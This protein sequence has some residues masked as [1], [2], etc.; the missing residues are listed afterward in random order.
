MSKFQN[1]GRFPGQPLLLAPFSL[2]MG[3]NSK[4]HS[5][6][7]VCLIVPIWQKPTFWGL[8]L[9]PRA[10]GSESPVQKLLA[11]FLAGPENLVA[12]RPTCQ[13]LSFTKWRGRNFVGFVEF[14]SFSLTNM[15][16]KNSLVVLRWF[17]FVCVSFCLCVYPS[18]RKSSVTFEPLDRLARNFQ[19]PL[20][21]LQV[22]F[23]LVTRTPQPA[24]SAKSIS[25]K[26]FV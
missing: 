20:N 8:G 10:P 11:R 13:N 1:F 25:F 22:I 26:V 15:Q 4:F 5:Q 18:L 12:I 16:K 23:G 24:V 14:P 21:S 17:V 3:T 7:F 9:T 6:H 2:A 19:G